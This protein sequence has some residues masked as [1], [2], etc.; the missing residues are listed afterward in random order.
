MAHPNPLFSISIAISPH[1]FHSIVYFAVPPVRQVVRANNPECRNRN[2]DRK[3]QP[4]HVI[5]P[6]GWRGYI[7]A[8]ESVSEGGPASY[9]QRLPSETQNLR[10]G[11]FG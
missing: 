11:A 10:V 4:I 2:S 9:T 8:T 5:I 6:R 3:L 1:S 7:L